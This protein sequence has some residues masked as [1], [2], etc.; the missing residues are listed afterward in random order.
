MST[1]ARSA[2]YDHLIGMAD[3]P[4]TAWVNLDAVPIDVPRIE[5]AEG[6]SVHEPLGM[7]ASYRTQQEV[8]V[9]VVTEK[10]LGDLASKNI[11]DLLTARFRYNMILP[12]GFR[13]SKPI[14]SRTPIPEDD[15]YRMPVFI[16]VEELNTNAS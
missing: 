6:P 2:V 8:V 9:F 5:V 16:R 11:I 7:N 4:P 10:G 13:I 15:V 14:E 1:S 3:R 12:G